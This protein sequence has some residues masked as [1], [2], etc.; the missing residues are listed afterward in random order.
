MAQV[1]R[2]LLDD[3]AIGA[4]GDTAL[5]HLFQVL[6]LIGNVGESQSLLRF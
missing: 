5:R 1:M 4:L 6:F 3:P 2:P